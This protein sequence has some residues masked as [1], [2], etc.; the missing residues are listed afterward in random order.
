MEKDK[1]NITDEELVRT[2]EDCTAC[3][4]LMLFLVNHSLSGDFV[5]RCPHCQ[6]PHCRKVEKGKVT[7]SR[8]DSRDTEE[9]E[10]LVHVKT[11]KHSSVDIKSSSASIFIRDSWINRSDISNGR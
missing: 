3:G 6:H 5:V 9:I 4:K 11:W 1:N 7:S 10:K 2:V 8:F